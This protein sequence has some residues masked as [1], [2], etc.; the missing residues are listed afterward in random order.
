M[1]KIRPL[2]FNFIRG[3][4]IGATLAIVFHLL[5]S[6]GREQGEN[7][8]SVERSEYR[9]QCAEPIQESNTVVKE[10]EPAELRYLDSL[11]NGVDAFQIIPDG[12]K[13]AIYSGRL[14]TLGEAY[15][16]IWVNGSRH[17]KIK[18]NLLGELVENYKP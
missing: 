1:G 15:S 7:T 18:L 8:R 4:L 3:F 13:F 6:C 16:I 5:T 9:E 2:I 14:Y 17:C 12:I 11:C 10:Q